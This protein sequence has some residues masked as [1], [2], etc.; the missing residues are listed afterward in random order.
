MVAFVVLKKLFKKNFMQ[1]FNITLL[2]SCVIFLGACESAEEKEISALEAELVTAKSSTASCEKDLQ[3]I[4][5]LYETAMADNEERYK[6]EIQTLQIELT[7]VSDQ[8]ET[9][10][11]A[12]LQSDTKN[13]FEMTGS[14]LKKELEIIRQ[15]LERTLP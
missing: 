11:K 12:K 9:E 13:D 7:I 8:L 4:I 2:F 14:Q 15:R 10:R 6:A 3:T 5:A 1:K